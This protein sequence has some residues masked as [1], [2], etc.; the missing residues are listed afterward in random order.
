MKSWHLNTKGTSVIQEV[1]EIYR[2]QTNKFTITIYTDNDSFFIHEEDNIIIG[3]NSITL[4]WRNDD[5]ELCTEIINMNKI[6]SIR[7]K[8]HKE[9]VTE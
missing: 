2:E 3:L 1:V 7:F 5:N 8:E 6:E 9:D 4:S